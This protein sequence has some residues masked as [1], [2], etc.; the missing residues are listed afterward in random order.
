VT[1]DRRVSGH[2][3]LPPLGEGPRLRL[4]CRRV[5]MIVAVGAVPPWLLHLLLLLLLLLGQQLQLRFR[6]R[7]FRRIEAG[8]PARDHE[9]DVVRDTAIATIGGQTL[10]FRLAGDP[11][12]GPPVLKERVVVRVRRRRHDAAELLLVDEDC[13]VVVSRST[14]VVVP[15]D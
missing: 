5:V 4:P 7:N 15:G 6:Q 12:V 10:G 3:P 11:R 1:D 14:L 2:R 13:C 8:P 9:L